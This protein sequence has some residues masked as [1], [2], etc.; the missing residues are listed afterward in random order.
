M[1]LKLNGPA[2][3][4]VFTVCALICAA[5]CRSSPKSTI[6]PNPGLDFPTKNAAPSVLGPN[7]SNLPKA[8]PNVPD[9]QFVELNGGYQMGA[10]FYALSGSPPDY[11]KLAM[12]ASQEYRSTAD[13]FRKRD[14]VQALKPQIDQ[15]IQAYKDTRHHYFTAK[16]GN[17]AGVSDGGLL[18]LRHYDFK[19]K[20]FPLTQDMSPNTYHYFNDAPFYSYAFTNGS[21]FQTFPLSDEQKAKEIEDLLT[22]TD[23]GRI[24]NRLHVCARGGYGQSPRANADCKDGS[25]WSGRR[26]CPSL[27]KRPAVA[28]LSAVALSQL[29]I[30]AGLWF[31]LYSSR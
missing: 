18:S 31:C 11:E 15:Q 26:G 2:V 29:G 8:D 30:R 9:A 23:I 27:S 20:S 16:V 13:G 21:G 17:G 10:L 4:I 5:G 14:I 3:A 19:T 24:S 22:D 6:F 7:F 25:Y 28:R 1:T 12:A